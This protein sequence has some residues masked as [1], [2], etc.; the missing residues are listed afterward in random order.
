MDPNPKKILIK[1]VRLLDELGIAYVLTGGIAVTIW[2]IPRYTGD[3]DLVVQ[4]RQEDIG[5]L[6][7]GLEKLSAF[8]YVDEAM[9]QDAV[10]RNSE[11]NYI[12]TEGGFKVDVW[13]PKD[14]PFV[15][16][17]F[18][19]RIRVEIDRYLVWIVSP[20]DLIVS[21]F[22]WWHKG[23]TKSQYDVRSVMDG[24]RDRLDWAYID[25]WAD[26]LGLTAELKIAK[27]TY[28]DSLF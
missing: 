24:Q 4:L 6:Y 3:A 9:I 17:C 25:M 22:D 11:F 1:V 28:G 2:G 12:D 27:A 19:R 21:K 20:E 18:T 5:R 15:R 7:S 26:T 8:G 13:I 14:T 23:S 16:S 10:L